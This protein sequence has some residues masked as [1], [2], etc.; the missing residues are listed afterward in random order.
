MDY[1]EEFHPKFRTDLK[2]LDKNI[3]KDIRDLHL[4]NI[5]KDPYFNPQLKGKL[6]HIRSYHFSKNG[7]AYRIA[8]EIK[9]E[10]K[11]IF[12]YMVAKRE[13]F[14]KKLDKRV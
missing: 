8:Y 1:A 5:L 2:K 7:T 4:N 12:H 13:N 6:S 11:I 9:E 3:I 10:N 14:Y